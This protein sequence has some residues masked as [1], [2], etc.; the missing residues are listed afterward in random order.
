[1]IKLTMYTTIYIL[2]L[3]MS[4]LTAGIVVFLIQEYNYMI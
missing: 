3:D 2:V 1:M 4:A